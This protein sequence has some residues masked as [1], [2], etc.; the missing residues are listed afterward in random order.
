[1]N[2]RQLS[3]KNSSRKNLI[4]AQRDLDGYSKKEKKFDSKKN[5]AYKNNKENIFDRS[6]SSLSSNNSP[7]PIIK[8]KVLNINRI[9]KNESDDISNVGSNKEVKRNN[10]RTKTVSNTNV[11]RNIKKTT[12]FSNVI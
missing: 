6:Y 12:I 8:N 2:N 4:R 3:I 7:F 11:T 1:M 10:R 9:I 5:S